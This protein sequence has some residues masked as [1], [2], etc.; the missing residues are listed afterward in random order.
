[1][2]ELQIREMTPQERYYCYSQSAQIE[3]QTGCI[4]HLRADM[5]SSGKG[6]FP[7]WNDHRGDLKTQEF[8]DELK[9][10]ID[11][12][13]FDGSYGGVLKDRDS[14]SRYCY[15]HMEASFGNDRE[16]GF[17]ADTPDHTYMLRLNPHKGEYNL[18][19]YCFQRRWLEQ[20]MKRAER[21]IRFITPDYREKFRIADGEQVRITD[22]DGTS[23]DC[24]CRYIDEAH[25][26]VGSNLFHICEFAER[27]EST[28][29]TVIP[30]R[31]DLPE[32]CFVY[33]ESTNEI[34]IVTKG[35]EGY[36]PLRQKP[37]GISVRKGA[38]L[39]N[40]TQGV[41]KAQAE[42]MKAGSLFGWD[43]PAADPKN[44]DDAGKPHRPKYTER[45]EAR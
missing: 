38:A 16:W 4:G 19:C 30:L 27:L 8:K 34:G 37:E 10:V 43:T 22:V 32:K 23:R 36:T 26:E 14:L 6:F 24:T 31:A 20:H 28:G 12:L 33:V 9:A 29:S 7:S 15:R 13:R 21:G 11:A 44:Y 39:L 1:M 2:M 18:Y 3:A 41:T 40:D 25:L 17:R 5:D 45:G 42:A 35:E